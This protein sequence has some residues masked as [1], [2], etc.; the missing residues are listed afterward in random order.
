MKDPLL[1]SKI[2]VQSDT[3]SQKDP[4]IEWKPLAQPHTYSLKEKFPEHRLKGLAH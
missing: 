2:I 1:H 4:L 3:C